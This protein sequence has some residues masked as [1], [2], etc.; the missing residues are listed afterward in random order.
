MEPKKNTS[1]VLHQLSF[2]CRVVRQKPFL[3]K[4][5]HEILLEVWQITLRI[6][7]AKS[8]DQMRQNQN[9]LAMIT[10]HHVRRIPET[11]H[12]LIIPSLQTNIVIA[13]SFRGDMSPLDEQRGTLG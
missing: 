10:K 9:Y 12:N 6:Q 4:N 13:A 11:G 7:E 3:T 5:E 1:A 2:Y 8:S